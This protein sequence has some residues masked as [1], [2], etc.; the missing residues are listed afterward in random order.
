MPHAFLPKRKAS[1]GNRF[2]DPAIPGVW[3]DRRTKIEPNQLDSLADG[4]EIPEEPQRIYSIPDAWA[5]AL[6][7]DRALY[8]SEHKLHAAVLGEWRGLLAMIGLKERRNFQGLSVRPVTLGESRPNS[9]ASV[10]GEL[11]PRDV[12][13]LSAESNWKSFHILRWQLPPFA[14]NHERAF[15][16]TS[17]MT[18]VATGAD[19]AGLIG[20]D[21]VPWF[22]GHRLED[23]CTHLAGRERKALA[24]W[25][26]GISKALTKVVTQ[27]YRKGKITAL[28]SDFARQLDSTAKAPE[29]LDDVVSTTMRMNF[30]DGIYL[31]LDRPLKGETLSASDVE[32]V[33]KGVE[34]VTKDGEAIVKKNPIAYYLIEPSLAQQWQVPAKEIAIYGDV[35]LATA[36][37]YI[38]TGITS[39]KF[40]E[41]HQWCTAGFFFEDRMIYSRDG[42][43]AF[44]GCLPLASAGDAKKRS[45][46]LPLREDVLKLFTAKELQANFSISW[47]PNGGATCYFRLRLTGAGGKPES[48]RIQ[49]TYTEAEMVPVEDLPLVCIWPDFRFKTLKWQI[50]YTFELWTSKTRDELKVKPWSDEERVPTA[51]RFHNLDGR[52]FELSYTKNYPEALI[53][54]TPFVDLDNHREDTAKGL[55]LLDQP[56]LEDPPSTAKV[57]LGVDFGSTGSDIYQRLGKGLP[58]ALVFKNRLRQITGFDTTRFKQFTREL[59]IP[60]RDWPT[61]E[62]LSVFQDF[63]DPPVVNEGAS[64]RM[65]VRDG[66]VLFAEDPRAFFT[67][68]RRRIKSNLKWGDKR[69][70]IAAKDFLRQLSIQ[71]AAEIAVQGCT[72][73]DFRYSYPTAFSDGDIANLDGIWD[74][75]VNALEEQTGLVFHLNPKYLDPVTKEEMEADN[76]EAITATRFFCDF[77]GNGEQMDIAGGAITVDIGGGTTDMAIWRKGELVSHSSILF[78]GRDIFLAPLAKYPGVLN[79]I[80]KRVPIDE[81][82]KGDDKDSAFY[83]HLDAIISK[84]GEELI[85]GLADQ[86]EGKVPELL[87]ILEIGL[88]GIA[89]YAGLLTRRVV[90]AK[91]FVPG[92]RIVIFAGGNGSKI[93]RWCALG[94]LSERSEIHRRFAA[95]FLA[96]ADLKKKPEEQASQGAASAVPKI[97][98]QLSQKPKSEV[99]FGLVCQDTP[100]SVKDDF[101]TSIAG[102]E[103][104]V[105]DDPE[106][107]KREWN[108]APAAEEIRKRIVRVNR[109][110]PFFQ[111]FLESIDE[112]F[113][114]ETMKDL[115]DRLAGDVDRRLSQ[116]AVDVAAVQGKE[117]KK[118]TRKREETLLRNEPIFIIA[119]KAYLEVRIKE[120]ARRA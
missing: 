30:N 101:A 63:G 64:P 76:R 4:L 24:E 72:E 40:K 20:A 86:P 55:L 109:D 48:C 67:G 74:G 2:R 53:C 51:N 104:V 15:G 35:S 75:I 34:T 32:I 98:I 8:N 77:T 47:L 23:P 18:L 44:P 93:F 29:T 120:W 31:V 84:H 21:E 83:A 37:R 96:G 85:K 58:K 42:A 119:L 14:H 112:S 13:M 108:N 68:D 1:T 38:G 25:I 110:F 7:F 22:D 5:R 19:Y 92:R 88:C 65:E 11:L 43:G 26:L 80:D 113:E 45:V 39:G 16:F 41:D 71:S 28:I 107:G 78:A 69:E 94:K 52:H 106:T 79:E 114:E 82:L 36:D 60:A 27:G 10:L 57:T 62:I 49:K 115:L 50:Y 89:Y 12:D 97:I 90:A 3:D 6:L 54:T 66:H 99:A 9:F 118:N 102:E 56:K 105:G 103:Y 73:A 59:F 95:A 91:E 81:L 87:A 116:L 33:T 46:V 117:K 17:P 61:D 111:R 70:R 100:L